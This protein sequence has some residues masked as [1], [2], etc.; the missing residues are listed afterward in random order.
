MSA[1][2]SSIF[3]FSKTAY[4][5][6]THVPILDTIFLQPNI[7]FTQYDAIVLTSKQA[8]TALEKISP[9]WRALPA[10][11]VAPKT[12]QM[13][14]DAGGRL[15]GHGNGYGDSLER[16]IVGKYAS[17]RWL[18]PRPK[19]V[20]SDFK[21][22]V[23]AHGVTLDDIIVYE[24]L[25]NSGCAGIVLP[26]SAILIF[27]S[28]FTIACFLEFYAFRPDFQV[29]VIGTTTAKALPEEVEYVMPETPDI[30]S[31][32]TLAQRLKRDN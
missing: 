3:L 4:P 26:D 20:A 6:V 32:V 12:E 16:I 31:C 27:T 22:R 2:S 25:C 30:E 13:V 7:D 24:T 29:V 17:L 15:L 21:E 19:V 28:P 18:Y 8:I 5:D 1:R 23:K 14:K 11:S 10:L 9:E